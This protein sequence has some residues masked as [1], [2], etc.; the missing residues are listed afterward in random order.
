MPYSQIRASNI[1]VALLRGV[2][3]DSDLS[4]EEF[5]AKAGISPRTLTQARRGWQL[6]A[7][8]IRR[9][10]TAC[11]HPIWTSKAEF[12]RQQA[13]TAW[14]GFDPFLVH[15]TKAAAGAREKG[16]FIRGKNPSKAVVFARLFAA[17][18]AAHPA[19]RLRGKRPASKISTVGNPAAGES[20]T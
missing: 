5:A 12:A 13:L 18:D 7:R 3:R 20:Q 15:Y 4:H 6:T 10:E 16:L 9:I 2:I 11:G 19:P 1:A 14:L 17:L 8:M